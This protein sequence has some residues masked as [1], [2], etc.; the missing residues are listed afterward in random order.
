M[1]Q[2]TKILSVIGCLPVLRDFTEDLIEDKALRYEAK[3][4]GNE[5]IRSIDRFLRF[6]SKD[7]DKTAAYEQNDLELWFRDKLKELENSLTE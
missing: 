5:I 7:I 4:H 6:V 2:E 1:K 3:K